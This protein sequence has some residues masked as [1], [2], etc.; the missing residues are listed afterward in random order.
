[1]IENLTDARPQ[2]GLSQANWV[3]EAQAEGGITRFLALFANPRNAEITVGPIR[4]VRPY[5]LDYAREFNSFFAHVGGNATA[6]DSIAKDG[7]VYDLNQFAVGAPT[8]ARDFSRK[9]AVEHTM[10]STTTKLVDY[11]VGRGAENSATFAPLVFS[12]AAAEGER[13]ASGRAVR[14]DFSAP[15]YLVHWDYDASTNS[16]SRT[17]A[18]TPHVDGNDGIPITAKNLIIQSV[19]RTTHTTRI[20]EHGWLFTLKGSGPVTILKNGTSVKGTWKREG[21]GRTRYYAADGTEIPLVRGTTWV[22][23]IHADTTVTL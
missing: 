5:F 14:I 9:V 12:D 15:A 3:Y 18:G 17:M 16:Y 6:L 23:V 2:K 22:E 20:N 21:N 7:G 13:G 10:Y 19:V 8:F 4:S 1:M 11:A